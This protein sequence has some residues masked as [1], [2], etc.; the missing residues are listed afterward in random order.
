MTGGSKWCS[1]SHTWTRS[2][3][4]VSMGSRGDPP[5]PHT[6]TLG[7]FITVF[8]AK[9]WK[10]MTLFPVRGV[11]CSP[12]AFCNVLSNVFSFHTF[13]NMHWYRAAYKLWCP[14]PPLHFST[15]LCKTG[16]D[17]LAA[18]CFTDWWG[19]MISNSTRIFSQGKQET[20]VIRI[21]PLNCCNLPCLNSLQALNTR[22]HA[23]PDHFKAGATSDG[24]MQCVVGYFRIHL[25]CV[26]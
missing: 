23:A 6:H 13:W 19:K 9:H 12:S 8:V 14:P 7:G 16:E 24:W 20:S 15:S 26:I 10:W 1:L 4:G 5:P 22:S 3:T 17:D 18:R 25:L 11:S 21:W 2:S